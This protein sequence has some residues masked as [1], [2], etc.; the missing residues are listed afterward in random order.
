MWNSL[1]VE[2]RSCFFWYARLLIVLGRLCHLHSFSFSSLLVRST[3]HLSSYSL[4]QARVLFGLWQGSF[5]LCWSPSDTNESLLGGG[6]RMV[7]VLFRWSSF[8]PRLP[9]P[10]SPVLCMQIDYLF[11]ALYLPAAMHDGLD[12]SLETGNL[13]ISREPL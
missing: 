6:R 10:C 2:V 5:L 3:A 7:C 11:R 9:C 4:V 1:D 12:I 8:P 13:K